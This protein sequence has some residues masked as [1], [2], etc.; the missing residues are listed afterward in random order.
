MNADGGQGA[1]GIEM[2]AEIKLVMPGRR[3]TLIHSRHKLCSSEPLPDE[4]KD[5]CLT[6]LH[7]VGVETIMGQRVLDET[8][9][10]AKHN[11][12]L[13]DGRIVRAS[14]VIYAI[15]KSTSSTSYLPRAALDVEG[16]AK[17][18]PK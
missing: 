13:A 16:C 12:K 15:S 9:E 4:F 5:K 10:N 6:A 7:E 2:A 1:V 18:T 17:V 14:E 8:I 11:L 3:V